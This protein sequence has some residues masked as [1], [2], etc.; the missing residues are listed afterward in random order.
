MSLSKWKEF[1][2]SKTE[3]GNKINY[4]IDLI[5]QHNIGQETSQESFAK[6]FKPV[7]TKLGDVIKRNLIK[8]QIRK[9]PT[10]KGEVPDYSVDI[11]PYEDMDVEGLIDY[12]D[13]V[14]PQQE[15]QLAPRPPRYK[16]SLE[17][18]PE[19]LASE[20]HEDENLNPPDAPPEY[21]DSEE[22]DY[23][24]FDEDL[25]RDRLNDLSL[26]NYENIEEL[27][28]SED[29]ENEYK[30]IHFNMMRKKAEKERNKL[31][32]SK[33]N[34]TKKYN[35]GEI[36]EAIRQTRNKKIDD[37]RAILTEYIKFNKQ[38]VKEL[39][40]KGSGIKA[41]GKIKKVVKER[42]RIKGYK[43]DVT[44]KFNNGTISK[45]ERQ[46]MNN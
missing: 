1:A 33:A 4:V 17:D 5:K 31:K 16:P 41:R 38:L 3:L 29:V 18:I 34:V 25:T 11:D 27:F 9:K 30:I 43:A 13:Y 44:K 36:N 42:N 35:K 39:E 10:K 28:N 32:G 20:Y 2:K 21:N 22:V 19:E 8:P 12:G 46:I 7:T 6:V 45:K 40:K 24:V 15:K 14:P 26:S 37:D 23:T